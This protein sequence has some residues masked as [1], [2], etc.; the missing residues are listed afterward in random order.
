MDRLIFTPSARRDAVLQLLRSARHLIVLSMFRCDDFT[1]VDEVAAAVKRGVKVQ[2]L[3]T[4][5]AR[6]WKYKLKD[7]TA[8]LR[9]LGADVRPY[10]SSVMKYHAK[11][12]V[13]D[14]GP[15]LVTSLNFTRK[16]FENTCDFLVFTENAGVVAGLK[17]LF[18]RDCSTAASPL[19]DITDRLIVGPDRARARLTELLGSAEH[20]IRII[21]HRVNDPQVIA[22]LRDKEH[23]GVSVRIVGDVRTDGLVAHGRMILI[24]QKIAV[25]GSIHLSPP[26]LDWRREIALVIEEAPIL[27]ELYDYFE[28]LARNEANIMNLW[29]SEPAVPEDDEEE[30]E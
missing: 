16:C 24:D 14:D 20:S 21:D 23:K 13:I 8:L 10:E 15:A 7:L 30:D 29:S 5:R 2:I 6:G 18:E 28:N 1:I 22:L 19:P 25:I 11:Y 26:S 4:Q 12:V 3:I 9:S 27:T 17:T